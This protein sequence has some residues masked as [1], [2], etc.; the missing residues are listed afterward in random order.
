MKPIGEYTLAEAKEICA[1]YGEDDCNESCVFNCEGYCA[2]EYAP[3]MWGIGRNRKLTE[4]EYTIFKNS[5]AKWVSRDKLV[6]DAG[7]AVEFWDS[8]P[9]FLQGTSYCRPENGEFIFRAPA[10]AFPSINPGDCFSIEEC[11]V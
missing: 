7:G 9:V 10:S 11:E 4:A 6:N 3:I 1:S 8:K 5:G 2:L